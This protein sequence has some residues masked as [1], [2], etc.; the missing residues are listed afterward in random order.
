LLLRTRQRAVTTED[1]E[2]LAR[3]A[4]VDVARV[5]C[6]PVEGADSAV[7]VLLVPSVEDGEHGSLEF[8]QMLVPDAD[9]EKVSR[10]LDERRTIGARVLVQAPNYVGLTVVARIRARSR[11]N[12]LVLE[13]E[14]L[15]ALYS[16]FHPVRGGPDGT[17]WPFGR[18]VV[19]GEVYAV[20]QRLADVDFLE[21][22]RLYPANPIERRR[23]QQAERIDLGPHDLVFSWGHH[24]MVQAP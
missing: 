18:A 20:L 9:F 6:V 5:H 14:A 3:A 15:A 23:D 11:A 19:T 4:A 13:E 17:G 12:P 8:H 16:Y 1:Y 21:E 24:V 22:V 7:R 2:H 10:Y